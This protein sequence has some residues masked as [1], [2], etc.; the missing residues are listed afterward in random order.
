MG[1][2]FSEPLGRWRFAEHANG[3]TVY[4]FHAAEAV[5]EIFPRTTVGRR[6]N[7]RLR[8]YVSTYSDVHKALATLRAATESGIDD[9][10]CPSVSRSLHPTDEFPKLICLGSEGNILHSNCHGFECLG[11]AAKAPHMAVSWIVG[12]PFTRVAESLARRAPK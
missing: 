1:Q 2:I 11:K 5:A 7:P 8:F 4:G 3:I 12:I 10:G 9:T 6:R